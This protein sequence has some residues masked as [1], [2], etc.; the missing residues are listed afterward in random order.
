MLIAL[1]I[2]AI[3]G[4]I[5]IPAMQDLIRDS[6]TGSQAREL[7]VLLTFARS[8]ALRRNG[9]IHVLVGND[10]VRVCESDACD[11]V[12]REMQ[13]DRVQATAPADLTFTNRGYLQPFTG[14]QINIEHDGA[15]TA[16]QRRCLRLDVTGQATLFGPACPEV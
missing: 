14:Q 16:G 15:N 4:T 6:R 1:A 5:G 3:I 7:L 12:L 9:D 11:N 2:I 10:L 13:W 8:E